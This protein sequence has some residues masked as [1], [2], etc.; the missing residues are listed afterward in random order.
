VTEFR[1]PDPKP[2]ATEDPAQRPRHRPGHPAEAHAQLR[3]AVSRF[4]VP[5][6]PRALWGAGSTFA[7]FLAVCATM[8]ASFGWSYALT[9]G[10]AVIAAGFTVRLFIIQHD[11]GHGSFLASRLGNT[12]L[13][14]LCG[15][16]TFTPYANWRRQHAGHHAVLNNLDRREGADLYSSALTVAEY[17]A[18]SPR[19]RL[20]YRM[21]RHPLVTGLLLPPLVFL[22]LYRVPLDTPKAWRRER[23][24]VHATN[25]GIAAAFIGLGLVLG[26][27]RVLLVQLPIMAIASIVGAWLFAV[28]H[29]FED[30]L[31]Q[32]DADW[33]FHAAALEGSS[34][35]RLPRIL[36]WFTGNIGFHHIHHLNPRVP[37]YRLGDCHAAIPALHAAPTLGLWDALRAPFFALWDERTQRMVGFGA[38]L[39]R[40]GE[41]PEL[42]RPV[43]GLELLEGDAHTGGGLRS[44]K[45]AWCQYG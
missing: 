35:L 10:L 15:L 40:D 29:R 27:E 17:Q 34:Y 39:G 22:L 44:P 4:Q 23:V 14:R 31:W 42:G 26:F 41:G 38:A 36:Q 9:L 12:I 11:C 1:Q 33:S 13:G 25:A 37:N 16:V 20:L 45:A 43:E 30:A 8:Y 19:R 32:R 21:S 7:G 24:S 2:A 6:L 3:A 18:R 28:Q 5:S